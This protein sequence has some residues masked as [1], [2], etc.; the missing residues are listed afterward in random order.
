MIVGVLALQGGFALHTK[1]LQELGC[2]VVEVRKVAHLQ[3]VQ[4][5]VIPGGESTTLLKLLSPEFR[6]AIKDFAHA[7]HP[8]LATCA[9]LIIL[10]TDVINPAQESLGLLDIEVE[11]NA[12]GR[13]AD[14]FIE[15]KLSW[16]EHGRRLIEA[17]SQKLSQIAT[18]TID[19]PTSRVSSLSPT[20]SY[21]E[22][23]FIRAPRITKVGKDVEVLIECHGHPVLVKQGRILG[24]TFHP[25]LSPNL[26]VIHQLL[27][28]Q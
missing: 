11:R 24:A 10:A 28:I 4:A 3:H 20:E 12:Y 6:Q 17:S 23:V 21:D 16:T 9:G 7:G 22:G 25:E 14:S 2:E 18:P 1:R 8:I 19:T 5:L 15:T 26:T 27:T 13:Q